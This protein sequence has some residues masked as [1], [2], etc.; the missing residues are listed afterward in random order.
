MVATLPMCHVKRL[1][2]STPNRSEI[3][4]VDGCFGILLAQTEEFAW[5]QLNGTTT[6]RTVY[7]SN[8]QVIERI[9]DETRR[10]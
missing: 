7:K 9:N 8:L 3:R 4:T 5:I 2:L 6:P 10:I 1:T